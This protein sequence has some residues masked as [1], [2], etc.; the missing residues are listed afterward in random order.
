MT[1]K[2]ASA[3][4]RE[5]TTAFTLPQAA[6]RAMLVLPAS[7]IRT[8]DM[9]GVASSQSHERAIVQLVV[10]IVWVADADDGHGIQSFPVYL[11]QRARRPRDHFPASDRHCPHTTSRS[12]KGLADRLPCSHCP[13]DSG[14]GGRPSTLLFNFQNLRPPVHLQW[15]G[16]W[17]QCPSTDMARHQQ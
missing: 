2:W 14:G 16:P 15:N 13:V 7:C 3:S 6:P 5:R 10:L 8:D 12:R 9:V 1:S 4:E 11:S 17:C